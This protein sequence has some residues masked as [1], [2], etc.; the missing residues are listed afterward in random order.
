MKK[1]NTHLKTGN[2]GEYLASHY[3]RQKGF[4]ILAAN[5][6]FGKAEVDIIALFEGFLVGIEV[7]TRSNSIHGEPA[8]FISSRKWQLLS[9]ALEHFATEHDFNGDIR[10]DVVSITFDTSSPSI[11][12]YPDVSNGM[13]EF[14]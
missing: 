14:E 7:K 2:T 8:E 13:D 10:F 6:R 4:E 5:Y 3:L 12:H 1:S 11:M 9:E